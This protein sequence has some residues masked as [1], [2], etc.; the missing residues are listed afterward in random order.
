M[1]V[2]YGLYDTVQALRLGATGPADVS[3][4]PAI[5]LQVVIFVVFGAALAV[6]ARGWQRAQRWARAPFIVAQVLGL[7]IGIPLAQSAG[8]VERIVGV[9]TALVCVI[10]IVLALTPQVS[11]ALGAVSGE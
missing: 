1:L 9:G 5:A 10:G 8:S 7:A 3:N 4:G 2:A 6:V 11:R